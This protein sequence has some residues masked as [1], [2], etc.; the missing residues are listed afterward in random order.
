[1]E[2]LVSKIQD[3]IEQSQGIWGIVLED[4][5]LGERWEL[6]GDE[7]F[8]AASVIKVPIMASVFAAIKKEE[9]ALTDQ[10]LLK[11]EDIVIGAGVLQHLTMGTSLSL[12]DVMTLMIIQSDNTATNILIDLVG[13]DSIA[14]TMKQ[15]GM[16]NSTFHHK[17][18]MNNT[19]NPNGR[20]QITAA[21]IAK[22]L[23]RM[24]TGELVSADACEQ[25]IG[26][27]K[28]QQK[29][30]C[31]PEKLPSPYSNF[32]NGMTAWELAH[33]GGW[34]PGIRHDAGIFFVGKR[35]LI[36]TVLSKDVDDLLSK[37]ILS[38]IGEE[39]YNYL[40]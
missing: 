8:Y 26:I 18:M 30:D 22:L 5:D 19:A 16:E 34:I 33:K 37:Q 20:N 15:A 35:R 1:M 29:T 14:E 23:N 17:L 10:I 28:K 40:R 32:N 38:E 13:V 4:L 21:D 2:K 9:L 6:N 3:L 12:L 7:L 11:Q 25:M 39:I 27:M 36:A 31:L 24:A